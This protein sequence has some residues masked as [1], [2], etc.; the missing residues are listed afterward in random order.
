[1]QRPP[2]VLG[3]P[4]NDDPAHAQQQQQQQQGG[5]STMS[6]QMGSFSVPTSALGAQ[7]ISQLMSSLFGSADGGGGTGGGDVN[8]F[9]AAAAAAGIT[10]DG[11]ANLTEAG[12]L[13]ISP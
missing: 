1:M 9:A 12:T 13:P 8:D 2:D 6:V 10:P 11:L 5:G 3:N 4:L 7:Q